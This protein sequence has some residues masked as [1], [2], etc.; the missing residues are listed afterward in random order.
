[1]NEYGGPEQAGH[2]DYQADMQ[3]IAPLVEAVTMLTQR[4]EELERLVVDELFGGIEKLYGENTRKKGIEGC[5]GKYG[6][7]FEPHMETLKA[8]NPDQDVFE[9]IYDLLAEVD[10]AQHDEMVGGFEKKIRTLRGIPDVE[11]SVEVEIST[12]SEP[13]KEEA[14]EADPFEKIRKQAKNFKY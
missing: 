3:M 9:I 10:E 14:K 12:E 8:I 13:A 5:R 6:S 2:S 7:M 1:M 4:V 11:K